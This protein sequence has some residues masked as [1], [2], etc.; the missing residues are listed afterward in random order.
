MLQRR[1]Q[2][3]VAGAG[4]VVLLAALFAFVVDPLLDRAADFDRRLAAAGRQL[5]VLQALRLDHQRQEQIIDRI[6]AQ[7]KRQPRTF[8]IFSHLEEVAGQTGI[9]DKIQSV[10]TVA[11]PPNTVYKEDSVEVKME[12]VTLAQLTEYL[13]RLERSPQVLKIKRLHIKPTR[14]SRQLLSVRFRLSVF[15]LMESDG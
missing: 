9:Q 15:S 6:D 12:G 4:V 14:E 1:E 2:I 3:L 8:V 10:N 5:A 13:H 7:L 11:G